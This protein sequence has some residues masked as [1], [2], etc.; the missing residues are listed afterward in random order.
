MIN[1]MKIFVRSGS[2]LPKTLDTITTD[3]ALQF[4]SVLKSRKPEK[5][6][7][8]FLPKLHVQRHKVQMLSFISVCCRYNPLFFS[9]PPFLVTR[10]KQS[11]K[12]MTNFEF[13]HYLITLYIIV[14]LCFLVTTAYFYLSQE[15]S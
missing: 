1:I 11:K 3:N 4:V 10:V 2:N 15:R 7:N 13:K 9:S 14:L 5:S 6:Q 12:R 8:R